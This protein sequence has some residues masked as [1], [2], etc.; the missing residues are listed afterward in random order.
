MEQIKV[1][2]VDDHPM[3]LTGLQQMLQGYAHIVV[4][5]SYSDGP[6]LLAG[7]AREQPDVL[8]LDIQLPGQTGDELAA[9]L[10]KQYPDLRV[11]ALTNFNSMVYVNNMRRLGVLGYLLKTTRQDTLIAAI[12]AVYKGTTFI[13]P[14]LREKDTPK[15]ERAVYSRLSLT[16]REK[17]ILQLLVNGYSN[18]EIAEE[19]FISFNTV[20]NYRARIF[21]KLDATTLPELIKQALTLGLANYK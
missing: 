11:L 21:S 17:Q 16:L 9:L 12:E 14:S 3:V 8:L 20:R 1:A 19:L 7:I 2:I 13:E 4:T 15:T 18:Q 10:R 5:G 6:E